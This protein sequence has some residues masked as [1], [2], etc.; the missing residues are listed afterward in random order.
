MSEQTDD[1]EQR[2]ERFIRMMGLLCGG[3]GRCPGCKQVW[4]NS[5]RRRAIAPPKSGVL[6]VGKGSGSGQKAQA[7]REQTAYRAFDPGTG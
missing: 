1:E 2:R 3:M 7:S 4:E 5:S 6:T